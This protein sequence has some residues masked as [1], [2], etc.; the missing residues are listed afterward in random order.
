MHP[1]VLVRLLGR[2]QWAILLQLHRTR[3]H[4]PHLLLAHRSCC[5]DWRGCYGCHHVEHRRCHLPQFH[6][7]VL[8]DL[9]HHRPL[10]RP[11]VL[12]VVS[13]EQVVLLLVSN[14]HRSRL[15]SPLLL[16]PRHVPNHALHITCPHVEHWR[17]HLPRLL[18]SLSHHRPLLR[19]PVLR[20]V[21]SEQVVLPPGPLRPPVLRIISSV[22]VVVDA[23][24]LPR[25]ARYRPCVLQ[26]CSLEHA[27][28]TVL[29]HA[30]RHLAWLPGRRRG[31]GRGR[32]SGSWFRIR[33]GSW[34]GRR[35]RRHRL[36]GY[37]LQLRGIR[38]T[39]RACA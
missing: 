14:R 7:G 30:R 15:H 27:L 37:F 4:P 5:P 16:H 19:P 33:R 22:Q 31:R 2:Q 29:L 18:H 26:H 9:S 34:H 12:R 13:S 1:R 11:P 6:F 38:G 28:D 23:A 25:F 32:R 17:C 35:R 39:L 21:S 8:H 10:L 3:Q 24:A 20:I 36:R